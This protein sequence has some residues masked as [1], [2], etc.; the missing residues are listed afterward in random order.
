MKNDPKRIE[1]ALKVQLTERAGGVG[2]ARTIIFDVMPNSLSE[3][4]TVN[5]NP[6]SLPQGP[7]QIYVFQNSNSRSYNLVAQFITQTQEDA[8]R[9]LHRINLLRSWTKPTF[10]S[11]ERLTGDAM[12]IFSPELASTGNSVRNR[13][14]DTAGGS[15]DTLGAPPKVLYLSAF[16]DI[17]RRGNIYKVPVVLTSL[18][19]TYDD[20][21]DFIPSRVV[22]GYEHITENTPVPVIM[23]VDM[24]L[25][26]THSPD[27]YSR[28]N[29]DAY[30]K[31]LLEGF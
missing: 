26:E 21:T 31:G 28:F 18:G 11:E 8:T 2:L 1:N 15:A 10:G 30:R 29:I 20:S 3:S 12:D 6:I 19:I 27:Q 23:S 13:M 17:N 22:A 5:Y 9:N 25:A 16:S 7:G 14:R 4:S 24:N